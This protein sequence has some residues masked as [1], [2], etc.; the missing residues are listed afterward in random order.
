MVQSVVQ[1]HGHLNPRIYCMWSHPGLQ[2][3]RR[4]RRDVAALR[5]DGG[6]GG[7]RPR[8]R[9]RVPEVQRDVRL[10]DRA[11]PLRDEDGR[12]QVSYLVDD[13]DT[14]PEKMVCRM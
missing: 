13:E 8:V 1:D 3:E 9:R 2:L 7:Q 10:P 14:G 12:V 6:D 5:G 4:L 11:G